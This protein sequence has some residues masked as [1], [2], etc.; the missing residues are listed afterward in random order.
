MRFTSPARLAGVVEKLCRVH[1]CHLTEF[2]LGIRTRLLAELDNALSPETST[3][4]QREDARLDLPRAI[5]LGHAIV[6]G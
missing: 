2:E 1:D 6:D 3:T 5:A 4:L